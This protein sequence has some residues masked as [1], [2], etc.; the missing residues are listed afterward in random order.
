MSELVSIY[1]QKNEESSS[2]LI[3]SYTK[4]KD[5]I[6]STNDNNYV[7]NN[8][9]NHSSIL[10][11]IHSKEPESPL[12]SMFNE[13]A[14]EYGTKHDTPEFLNED[15]FSH[16]LNVRGSRYGNMSITDKMRGMQANR[17]DIDSGEISLAEMYNDSSLDNRVAGGKY[18]VTISDVYADERK[19]RALHGLN[20][21]GKIEVAENYQI[22]NEIVKAKEITNPHKLELNNQPSIKTVS[23][24]KDNLSSSLLKENSLS[25]EQLSQKEL[26]SSLVLPQENNESNLMNKYNGSNISQVS[27]NT[28][29][30]M[31]DII[32][33]NNL[34]S[35]L[36]KDRKINNEISSLLIPDNNEQHKLPEVENK[37]NLIDKYTTNNSS[38]QNGNIS[39]LMSD[40]KTNELSIESSLS[41]LKIG[42]NNSILLNNE[43]YK[44]ES[45]NLINK[46]SGSNITNQ[47]QITANLMSDIQNKDNELDKIE[48]QKEKTNLINYYYS[49][50]EKD[51]FLTAKNDLN[52]SPEGYSSSA[53]NSVENTN[54]IKIS[55]KEKEDLYLTD[56]LNIKAEKENIMENN[57]L[58]INGNSLALMSVATTNTI[59]SKNQS[60]ILNPLDFG[61]QVSHKQEFENSIFNGK[62][63]VD[64][65]DIDKY[66][67]NKFKKNVL[68]E[69]TLIELI[70][71]KN[72]LILIKENSENINQLESIELKIKEISKEMIRKMF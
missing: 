18:N 28:S 52:V 10:D 26:S 8:H 50:E 6:F 64:S 4:N 48:K 24:Q 59:F 37:S 46:Y 40:I 61:S 58:S 47:S 49:I 32:K 51:S 29:N 30:L 43:T 25:T 22:D 56:K 3:D 39:N 31:S 60:Q 63:S 41:K 34:E 15:S 38:S 14:K 12:T 1:M 67:L 71:L 17:L 19:W 45:Q 9:S 55:E 72:E 62:I 21:D 68:S 69:M 13:P 5:S 36:K 70:E 57:E 65:F 2:S 20:T 66:I 27:N 7:S 42:D 53:L 23:Y 33:E 16:D 35:S 54:I 44:E 11:S